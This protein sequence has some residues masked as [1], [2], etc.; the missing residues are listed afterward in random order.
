MTWVT[1][2]RRGG[3]NRDTRSE[4]WK[5]RTDTISWEAKRWAQICEQ[6]ECVDWWKQLTVENTVTGACWLKLLRHSQHLF[7]EQH[8]EWRNLAETDSAKT[9]NAKWLSQCSNPWR[10]YGTRDK[11]RWQRW[12]RCQGCTSSTTLRGWVG[13]KLHDEKRNSKLK[14]RDMYQSPPK[15]QGNYFGILNR[16]EKTEFQLRQR[17][18]ITRVWNSWVIAWLHMLEAAQCRLAH[19]CGGFR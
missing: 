4:E 18:A 5:T 13:M 8:L 9:N 6:V 19:G 11:N 16:K 7:R 1:W 14:L 3:S 2:T 10:F 15:L 17:R 12:W